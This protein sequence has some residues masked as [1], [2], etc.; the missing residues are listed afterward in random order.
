[1]TT[2]SAQYTFIYFEEDPELA[3]GP[4]TKAWVC[5]NKRSGS[6]IGTVLWESGWRQ[7]VFYP[8]TAIFSAG[9]LR[10]IAAFLDMVKLERR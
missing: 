7:Y 5:R 10:D 9:C 6:A 3:S 1:M 4:K 2:V 8:G